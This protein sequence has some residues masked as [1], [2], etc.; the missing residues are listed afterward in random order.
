MQSQP[1]L[2]TWSHVNCLPIH[3]LCHFRL[4]NSAKQSR[5][6]NCIFESQQNDYFTCNEFFSPIRTNV[7][8]HAKIYTAIHMQVQVGWILNFF[9]DLPMSFVFGTWKF[10]GK[11]QN[12]WEQFRN[13]LDVQDVCFYWKRNFMYKRHLQVL[14]CF[15]FLISRKFYQKRF[16]FVNWVI[17]HGIPLPTKS[18]ILAC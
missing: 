10:E 7:F 11:P 13:A 3:A 14:F 16:K 8:S 12:K 2:P 18:S 6:E 5:I 15:S 9:I 17:R 4:W 1:Q